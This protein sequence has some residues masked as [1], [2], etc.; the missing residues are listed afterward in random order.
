MI[1][2]YCYK[3]HV[4]SLAAKLGIGNEYIRHCGLSREPCGPPEPSIVCG[5]RGHFGARLRGT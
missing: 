2:F 5:F 3:K 4:A 1:S